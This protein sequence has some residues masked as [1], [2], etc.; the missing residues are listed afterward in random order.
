MEQA[1]KAVHGTENRAENKR[2]KQRIK[3]G[4]ATGV[5]GPSR[6]PIP[7]KSKGKESN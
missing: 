4:A 7:E 2:A 3:Q 6:A 1:N 5:G